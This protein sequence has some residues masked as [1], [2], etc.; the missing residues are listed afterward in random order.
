MTAKL[1][2]HPFLALFF[3]ALALGIAAGTPPSRTVELVIEGFS[4]ILGKILQ[5]TGIGTFLGN[6]VLGLGIPALVVVFLISA[7][8]KTG[9]GS[10][11][12]TMVTAP[13]IIYPVLPTLGLSPILATMAVCAGAMVCVNVNDSFFWVVTGFSGLDIASGYKTLTAMS[14]VMG[15]VALVVIAVAGPLVIGFATW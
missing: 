1:K 15:L 9:Q 6:S 2:V 3:T 8:I 13:A 4:G 10:S 7:L 5:E 14:I 11:M 12:V